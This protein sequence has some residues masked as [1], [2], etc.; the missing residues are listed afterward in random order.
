ML[1]NCTIDGDCVIV[2]NLDKLPAQVMVLDLCNWMDKDF[3][4]LLQMALGLRCHGWGL[5][6][7]A[8][9]VK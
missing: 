1:A 3:I 6:L 2:Y 7:L 5:L 8:S 9:A 4:Q